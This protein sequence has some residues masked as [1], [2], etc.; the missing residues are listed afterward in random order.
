M[1]RLHHNAKIANECPAPI[2]RLFGEDY[3]PLSSYGVPA[4]RSAVGQTRKEKTQAAYPTRYRFLHADRMELLLA[5]TSPDIEQCPAWL[6][7][8]FERGS[9]IDRDELSR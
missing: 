8:A 5:I 9:V 4:L 1:S 3:A 7:L 2:D 6:V